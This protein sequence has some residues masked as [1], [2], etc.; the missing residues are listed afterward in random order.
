[1]SDQQ[2]ERLVSLLQWCCSHFTLNTT[3]RSGRQ[4]TRALAAD[5]EMTSGL[6]P[7]IIG[8]KHRLF[9]LRWVGEKRPAGK[10]RRRRFQRAAAVTW[11][12]SVFRQKY[13]IFYHKSMGLISQSTLKCSCWV[14]STKTIIMATLLNFSWNLCIT[15]TNFKVFFVWDRRIKLFVLLI[16][17]VKM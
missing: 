17:L 9:G 16:L 8:T 4:P 2:C 12:R 15:E 10:Q 14:T 6:R 1:M 13:E 5:E 3:V 11:N 7:V